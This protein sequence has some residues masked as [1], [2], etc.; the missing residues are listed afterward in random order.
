MLLRLSVE[1]YALIE[2]LL[3][4]P[5]PNFNIITGETGAGKS[6]LLGAVGLLLGA[7]SDSSVLRDTN[8]NCI[9]EG[10]FGLEG[11]HL[12][13]FF[14]EN[15][16]DYAPETTLTRILTPAGKSRSFIN[17]LPVPLTLLRDL[18]TRLIDIHSQHRNLILSS[19]EFRISVLDTVADNGT[20]LERYG[21][22]YDRMAELGRRLEALRTAAAEGRRNEEWLRFQTEEL[23]AADLREGEQSEIETELGVLE[24]ADRI[25]DTL[26]R[27]RNDLDEDETGILARL[28]NAETA[29]GHLRRDFPAAG[30]YADR[31]RSTMEE[32]KD[33]G[34]SAAADCERIDADPERMARLSA[35]LDTLL[36]L[37]QKHRAADEAELLALRDRCAAQLAAIVHGDEAIA[38]AEAA[39]S[40]ARKEVLALGK[41]LH[42]ARERAAGPF[43]EEIVRTLS[44]LGMADT[45]FEAAFTSVEPGRTGCD[46]V[47]FLFS[48]NP[49]MP[50]QRI[51]RIAS[52]GELS[53]VMLALKALLARRMQLPTIIFDEI[54][55][56]VSGRIADAMGE[57]IE[58]LSASLQVIDI[59]HLPQVASKGTAHFVVSKHEGRTSIARLTDEERATEIA[60]M[61]SGSAVTEAALAQ[62]RILLG[63]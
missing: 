10:T 58:Q 35:R 4:E 8:R 5:D 22:A 47:A 41:Q 37:Q 27:L 38:E 45:R 36:A 28:K 39:L 3:L 42:D 14:E 61:L 23:T 53:R 24:H 43:S 19:G 12:E 40:A 15:E 2:E 30:N 6:I 18:G 50:P 44:R 20:L 31:I 7:R 56:G 34:Q 55:T 60:K 57:I 33:I 46:E 26:T 32:L 52:G 25:G 51:E 1:N 21:T 62:A 49:G 29:L 16:L 13:S 63:R 17:D 11:L 54:D 9:I 59:T 48:A